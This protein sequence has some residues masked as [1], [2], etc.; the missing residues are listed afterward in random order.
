[1]KCDI[2]VNDVEKVNTV[3]GTGK[4]I[5]RFFDANRK[6][7]F[8]PFISYRIP[9]TYVQLLSPQTYH[10]FHGAHSI[11][12]VINVHMVLK[13]HKNFIPINKQERNMWI[14]N[15]ISGFS[16]SP[17]TMYLILCIV[18]LQHIIFVYKKKLF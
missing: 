2:P 7:L 11:N 3:I 9:T 18:K 16:Y 12:K 4:T 1:M 6:Y 13:N 5:H 10:Q 14:P 17:D 15:D 8:L